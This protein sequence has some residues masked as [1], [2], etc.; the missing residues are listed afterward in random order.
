MK[1]RERQERCVARARELAA[2]GQYSGYS[3]IV[4]ILHSEGYPEA[5]GWLTNEFLRHELDQICAKSQ[6][7]KKPPP[8]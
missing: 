7:E 3:I 8:G 6:A 5:R 1:R 2:S 4:H